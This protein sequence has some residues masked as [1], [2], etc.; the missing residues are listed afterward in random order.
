MTH[1]KVKPYELRNRPEAQWADYYETGS[2]WQ[3]GFELVPV[4]DIDYDRWNDGRYEFYMDAFRN[5]RPADPVRLAL[6]WDGG[7]RWQVGDGNHRVAASASMG[8]THVPALVSRKVEGRP[9][10]MPPRNLYEEIHGRELL[11]L[12]EWLRNKRP[13]ETRLYFEWGGVDPKGYWLK[14]TDETD[15]ASRPYSEELRVD[16]EFDDRRA[17]ME[18]MGRRFVYRGSLE[19]VRKAVLAHLVSMGRT[20]AG[21]SLFRQGDSFS[22]RGSRNRRFVYNS[23]TGELLLGGSSVSR[24]SHEREWMESGA[25][26]RFDD[27]VRGWIGWGGSYKEGIIHFAPP[28]S[29]GEFNDGY[30]AVQM[31]L[32]HG[33]TGSTVLRGFMGMGE[34][35]IDEKMSGGRAARMARMAARVAGA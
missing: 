18:W 21:T 15:I 22:V 23:R 4:K 19:G 33:A 13:S 25:Q 1:Y 20:A 6:P 29:S 34:S 11:M 7:S 24:S 8:Y 26:G 12:V 32:R 35:T 16:V 28:I 9:R 5:G 27:C 3:D 31:F 10:G 30:E 17:G 2:Y 14:V